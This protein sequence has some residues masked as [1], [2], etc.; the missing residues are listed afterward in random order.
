[1]DGMSQKLE[2][3]QA[4]VNKVI[5]GKEDVVKK[6]LAAVIAGG[7][8][9]MEDIPGVGKT[10]LATTFAKSMSMHYKRVQFTPDVLPSDILGFSMYNSATKD[11]EYREGAV[12]TNLFLA[13]EINRTSPKTQSALLEVMEEKTATVDGVTRPLP[14]PF[15]VI[16]TENPYG[17]S[18]TQMLPESQ[19]DRFMVCLSMGYP[20][21]ADAVAILKGNAG[22]PLSKVQEVISMEEVLA[23]RAMTNDLYVKDEIY[24]YIVNLVEATRTMEIFSM[25][26]SPRGTIALLRMAKAMAVIDGRDYVCAKDV[27]DVARD[28]LGHRVKLSARGK[29][30]GITM[31]QAIGMVIANVTAPRV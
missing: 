27:Q 4:E 25:G 13:D 28:V 11:F 10:T 3:V 31:Q 24:E 26:A 18:G 1:M 17:S 21:H 7:H 23:L 29:A 2:Q 12:F 15:V 6:V 30:Q 16:A 22:K 8:I 20:S 5:K 19:L 9:L 14:D